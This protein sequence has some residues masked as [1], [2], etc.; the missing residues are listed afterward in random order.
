MKILALTDIHGAYDTAAS[1]LERVAPDLLIIGGDLTTVGSV[2]EAE[3]ALRRFQLLVPALYCVA[4]NMDLPAHDDLFVRM[5][6]SLNGHG[7]R[8]GDLGLCGASA[9]PHSKLRTP[10]ERSEEEIERTLRAGYGALSGCRKVIVVPH[11]PPFGTRVDILHSGIHVGSS[12][13]REVIEDLSPDLVL[14]GHIHEA[15]GEDRIGATKIVNCGP[16]MNG[17]YAVVE[18]DEEILVGLHRLPL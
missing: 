15:R 18:A 11:A 16:A 12:G 8:L 13:V 2:A 5:G 17:S 7:V 6:I 1:I 9:A 14:C 4:G 3:A 10:Y